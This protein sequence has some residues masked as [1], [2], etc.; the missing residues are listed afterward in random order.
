MKKNKSRKKK[1]SVTI[2]DEFRRDIWDYRKH[3]GYVFARIG[4]DLVYF[5]ITHKKRKGYI[6]MHKNPDPSDVE[7][8]YFKPIPKRQHE[9]KFGN[10]REKWMLSTED[11]QKMKPYMQIPTRPVKTKRK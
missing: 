1:E 2:R 10:I 7:P 11:L 4:K 5:M 8:A 3:Y 6:K 9:S